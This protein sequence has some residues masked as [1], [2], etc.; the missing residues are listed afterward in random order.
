MTSV[1]FHE[2]REHPYGML[3]TTAIYWP[4]Q[5]LVCVNVR[6]R[7]KN[8]DGWCNYPSSYIASAASAADIAKVRHLDMA[9]KI[10]LLLLHAA[11]SQNNYEV[12]ES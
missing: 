6:V 5:G 2:S 12:Y 7:Y 1:V 10:D 11:D 3:E 8:R 4:S 9:G